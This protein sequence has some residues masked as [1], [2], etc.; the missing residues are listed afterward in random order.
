MYGCNND[1][2]FLKD[3]K[4]ML[5]TVFIDNWV[6]ELNRQLERGLNRPRIYVLFCNFQK[7]KISVQ[8]TVNSTVP[9]Q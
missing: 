9:G 4:Q 5:E 6:T 8:Y 2:M 7:I 3:V 1:N